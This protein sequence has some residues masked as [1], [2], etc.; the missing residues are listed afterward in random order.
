ML[1]PRVLTA[2][3][4]I[5]VVILLV[6]SGGAAYAAFIF[7]IIA[8]SLYEYAT[9]MKLGAKP[10]QAPALYLFG[11]LLPAALYFDF[12][13]AAQAGGDNYA[14]F[15][16]ALTVIGVMTLELFSAKKYLE[17]IGLTL[18]GIF[19]IS[20]CMFHLVA[21]RG[22][23]P[24][25]KQLTFMLLITVWIMDTAAYF[26]GKS[27]GRRQLSSIS[28][29]KTWEGAAAGFIAAV[30]TSVGVAKLLNAPVSPAFAAGAGVLIG[31]FGQVSDIAESM[32]KRAVGAKDSSNLLPGHGGILD[33][34]DSYIFLAP[35]IYY[36]A[37]FTR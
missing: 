27:M 29:K 11:L 13:S 17:R 15:I 33:R 10:V 20:W 6:N 28:P 24:D 9:L 30:A 31:I 12:Y 21:I 14:G 36:Y 37:V 34:F 3:F 23:N 1:L 32:I 8:L 18:L 16:L 5:P 19:M 22:L 35:I 7:T 4:G 25:G 26:F 2:L